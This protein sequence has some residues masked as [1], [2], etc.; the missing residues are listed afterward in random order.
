MIITLNIR[1]ENIIMLSVSWKLNYSALFRQNSGFKFNYN[2]HSGFISDKS[3]YNKPSRS[4]IFG[5]GPR[6]SSYGRTA[7]LR[8]IL[9]PCDEEKG[10]RFSFLLF[11][12]MEQ[13]WNETDRGKPKY[14]GK[15]LS[16]CHLVH[17]KSHMD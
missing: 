15:N 3:R 13:R 14:S 4:R 1:R 2:L 6:S 16:Q 10:N 7:A 11:Q 12:V 9:Q 17:H 8:L 5:E